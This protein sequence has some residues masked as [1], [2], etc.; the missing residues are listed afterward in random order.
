MNT[1]FNWK[2]LLGISCTEDIL[3]VTTFKHTFDLSACLYTEYLKRTNYFFL[4]AFKNLSK[5]INI[6]TIV[7]DIFTNKYF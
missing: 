3:L 4:I 2:V 5:E 7:G 6:C 1:V